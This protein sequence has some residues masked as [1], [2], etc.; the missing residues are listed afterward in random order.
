MNAQNVLAHTRCVDTHWMCWHTLQLALEF[1]GLQL[2][3]YFHELFEYKILGARGEGGVQS[4]LH[5]LDVLTHTRCAGTHKKKTEISLSVFWVHR[6]KEGIEASC[7]HGTFKNAQDV[8]AHTRCDD[9]HWMCWHTLQLALEFHG[10]QLA[11][12]FHGL[13]EN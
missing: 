11:V 4:L 5:T 13:F 12:Y 2:A 7:T 8:L 10:L 9:T 6:V 1:H 3:V